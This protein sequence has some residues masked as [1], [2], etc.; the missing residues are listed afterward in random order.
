MKRL[1]DVT[2][3]SVMATVSESDPP[4]RILFFFFSPSSQ[5]ENFFFECKK[6]KKKVFT[7]DT[8]QSSSVRSKRD[9]LEIQP[10]VTQSTEKKT[11]RLGDVES[12]LSGQTVWE[13]HRYLS[14]DWT[15][16]S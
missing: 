7:H 16:L 2:S 1:C 12:Y 3:D 15:H 8:R 5:C 13:L 14:G 4:D 6:K 11:T 9:R 10:Q